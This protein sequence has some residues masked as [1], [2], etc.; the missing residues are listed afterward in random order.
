MMLMTIN[1]EAAV[2]TNKACGHK[3]HQAHPFLNWISSTVLKM[4][5]PTIHCLAQFLWPRVLT[6]IQGYHY[7]LDYAMK[8]LNKI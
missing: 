4:M 5:P 3:A 6:F 8:F 7:K 2:W 1:S